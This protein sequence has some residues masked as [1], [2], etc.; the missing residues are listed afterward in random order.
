MRDFFS[1]HL[2]WGISGT[3][4]LHVKE[5]SKIWRTYLPGR[6][7]DVWNFPGKAN[8]K[9]HEQEILEKKSG[10]ASCMAGILGKKRD[11]FKRDSSEAYYVPSSL[12]GDFWESFPKVREF[13]QKSYTVA[14]GPI[15]VPAKYWDLGRGILHPHHM[16]PRETL[17]KNEPLWIFFTNFS[18]ST[19]PFESRRISQKS[20]GGCF[21]VAVLV[22]WLKF[23]PCTF[24]PRKRIETKPHRNQTL[25]E[26]SRKERW[27][28]GFISVI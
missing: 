11:L 2:V 23:R 12:M 16:K 27:D 3:I 20:L 6:C 14:M 17:G 8:S 28:A 15:H 18:G 7:F 21:Q 13:I 19:K 5:T 26:F 22:G 24:R 4:Q 25:Y 9:L 10:V 1:H